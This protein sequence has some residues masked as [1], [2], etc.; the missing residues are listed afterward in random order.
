L[1]LISVLAYWG[2]WTWQVSHSNTVSEPASVAIPTKKTAPN[3]SLATKE[4][5]QATPPITVSS[6]AISHAVPDFDKHSV[7][8]VISPPA[9]EASLP[10]HDNSS[11]FTQ[12]IL[13]SKK[14]LNE[15]PEH[16]YTLQLSL[17]DSKDIDKLEQLLKQY[18]TQFGID[19]LYLYPTRLANQK[20]FGIVY[21]SFSKR[22]NAWLKRKELED[23]ARYQAQ[24]RTIEGLKAEIQRSQSED[25]W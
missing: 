10:T 8:K 24:L 19:N 22:E 18:A 2:H 7:D 21:N 11:L 23:I 16:F 17:V 15:T 6:N 13:Q 20:R 9:T 12:R 25:L 1:I 3:I 4:T 5:T 14:W